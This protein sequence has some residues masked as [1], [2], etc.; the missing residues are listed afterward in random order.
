MA[1]YT[2]HARTNDDGA[3]LRATPERL[4][5]VR[6]G[7]YVWA[8]L[9]SALWLIWHRLWLAL[10]GYL[11]LTAALEATMWALGTDPASWMAVMVVMF[12]SLPSVI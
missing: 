11:V 7:F 2:V 9:L 5:F 12:S 1:V 3:D 8:A 4:V 6:D 10:I